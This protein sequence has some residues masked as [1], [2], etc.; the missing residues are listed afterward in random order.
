[1]RARPP[2]LLLLSSS[3]PTGRHPAAAEARTR[4]FQLQFHN[5]E[6]IL[7]WGVK[8]LEHERV[9]RDE[10]QSNRI[11]EVQ[12]KGALFKTK[13]LTVSWNSF[14]EA[15]LEITLVWRQRILGRQCLQRSTPMW[16]KRVLA[17]RT[18]LLVR[19]DE[20]RTFQF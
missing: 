6:P 3:T 16:R 13:D 2:A 10:S 17:R 7:P 4:G 5:A 15:C 14:S 19:T 11:R 20:G 9:W 1:M 8:E 12:I 18:S